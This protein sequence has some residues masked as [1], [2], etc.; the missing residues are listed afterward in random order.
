MKAKNILRF[1]SAIVL[2]A[3]VAN[4][5]LNYYTQMDS[6]QS[7]NATGGTG[8]GTFVIDT[9]ANTISYT[10]TWTGMAGGATFNSHIHGP[11]APGGGAGIQQSIGSVSPAVG[12]WSYAQA[13]EASILGGLSYVNIHNAGFPAGEI[14]GQICPEPTT[15][16][17]CTSPQSCAIA[18][19][20]GGCGNTT[21]DGA[22]L[23]FAGIPSLSV[24]SLSITSSPVP[25]NEFGI[26]FMGPSQI[27]GMPIGTGVAF[28]DGRRCV[29]GS[30]LR[31]P[32]RNSGAGGSTTEP[33]GL[34]AFH[35][36]IMP[37]DTWNFQHWYRNPGGS[38]GSAFNLSNALSVQFTI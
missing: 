37:G 15:Y 18:D 3:G 19:A 12:V 5:Q 14:R 30:T 10:I 16:C 29:G 1:M 22:S 13:E 27:L 4:A 20:D 26:F 24:G 11:A 34:S 28:G 36:L 25:A 21:G 8:T 2:T 38:C 6:A 35:G 32:L 31:F 23:T 7:G 17:E 9:A 33:A